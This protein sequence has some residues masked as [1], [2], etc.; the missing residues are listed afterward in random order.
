MRRILDIIFVGGGS[1]TLFCA[2]EI[3]KDKEFL[4]IEKG[5]KLEERVKSINNRS[6]QSKSDIVFGVGG[7]GLFFDGKLNF[8][9]SIGGNH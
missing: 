2:S 1:S 9:T 3:G 4:I 8:S 7:A 5:K 6:S